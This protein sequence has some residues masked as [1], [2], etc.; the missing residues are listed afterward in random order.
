MLKKKLFCNQVWAV[1][2]SG[3]DKLWFTIASPIWSSQPELDGHYLNL[4]LCSVLFE[5]CVCCVE[6]G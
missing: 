5:R 6:V 3:H 4:C 1:L 2:Q